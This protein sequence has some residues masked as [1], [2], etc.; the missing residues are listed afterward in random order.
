[1]PTVKVVIDASALNLPNIDVHDDENGDQTLFAESTTGKSSL[2]SVAAP[3][4]DSVGG[5]KDTSI[6]APASAAA[7]E[8]GLVSGLVSMHRDSLAFGQLI[9]DANSKLG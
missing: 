1:M 5:R 7:S 4:V 8:P 9:V 2:S 3:F 6:L